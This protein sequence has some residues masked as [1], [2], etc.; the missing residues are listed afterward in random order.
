MYTNIVFMGSPEFAV[1][2]LRALKKNFTIRGVV[3]QPDRKAGRGRKLT[4]PPVKLVAQEEDVPIIQP[5]NVN[6]Q[7]T[8]EQ[9]RS[10]DPQ[11]IVVAAF[12]QILKRCCSRHCM[13]K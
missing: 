13:P 11:V 5:E 9:I 8:L 1:P 10:W 3:T 12:G 6:H 7:K 2:S 4:P